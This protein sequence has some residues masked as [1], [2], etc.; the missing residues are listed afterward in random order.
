MK[1]YI[2]IL[3]SLSL[4]ALRVHCSAPAKQLSAAS[5]A[6][7]SSW[8][9]ERS[10][11][12]DVPQ[13]AQRYLD[14]LSTIGKPTTQHPDEVSRLI[15][16]F[17][18]GV[19]GH[20]LDVKGRDGIESTVHRCVSEN[21]PIVR[22]LT[23]FPIASHKLKGQFSL[24]EWLALRTHQHVSKEIKSIYSPG[25]K[26]VISREPYIYQDDK[27]GFNAIVQKE[28][29]KPLY[30]PEQIQRYEAALSTCVE[31]LKPHVELGPD[32]SQVYRQHYADMQVNACDPQKLVHVGAFMEGELKAL[33]DSL[34]PEDRK[35]FT[36]KKIE[37]CAKSLAMAADAGAQR[38]SKMVKEHTPGFSDTVYL[39]LYGNRDDLSGG[40]V[41]TPMIKGC[42]GTPWHSALVVKHDG[43]KLVH[44][45]DV[46]KESDVQQRTCSINGLDLPY[47]QKN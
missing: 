39:T 33:R 10:S 18:L 2:N 38:K 6:A 12:K 15:T 21:K 30:C 35:A 24:G 40:K 11:L 23:A 5:A 19:G 9:G 26:L 7:S 20:P 31:P 34:A 4:L 46:L 37:A 43:V 45:K 47:L 36:K 16:N 28:L 41:L 3:L 1:V 8:P 17:I 32:L 42:E 22:I 13:G 29:G 25:S 27:N 14:G 44:S